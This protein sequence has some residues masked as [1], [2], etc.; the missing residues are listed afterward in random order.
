MNDIP[1]IP[2]VEV[3]HSSFSRISADV[4]DC[5]CEYCKQNSIFDLFRIKNRIQRILWIFIIFLLVIACYLMN[6]KLFQERHIFIVNEEEKLSTYDIP[7]PAVTVC[8]D[9]KADHRKFKFLYTFNRIYNV[10]QEEIIK[11]LLLERVLFPDVTSR[12][13]INPAIGGDTLHRPPID[14]ALS[15]IHE[16]G[17]KEEDLIVQCSIDNQKKCKWTK[18]LTPDGLCYSFNLISSKEM[19]QPNIEHK[20]YEDMGISSKG[21]SSNE[22]YANRHTKDTYPMR[23]ERHQLKFR[24][25]LDTN[26][27]ENISPKIYL[28]LG[29]FKGFYIYVHHPMDYPYD[30]QNRVFIPTNSKYD[31]KIIPDLML[32]DKSLKKYAMKTRKCSFGD[33]DETNIK[34]FNHFSINNCLLECAAKESL[35]FCECV[36]FFMP[37]ENKTICGQSERH[38]QHCYR[39]S[40]NN[41]I[42]LDLLK[43]QNFNFSGS[44]CNCIPPCSYLSYTVYESMIGDLKISN[45][46][47]QFSDVTIRFASTKFIPKRRQE[48]SSD[49]DM[50]AAIGG[51]LGLFIGA[52]VISIIEFFYYFS[53]KLSMRIVFGNK[54][55]LD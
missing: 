15:R 42:T 23:A 9:V 3:H 49:L 11:Y 16:L 2:V 46:S 54:V 48:S 35:K 7:F 14:G 43:M 22:G 4:K 13:L 21:W 37:N 18:I 34:F 41:M 6:V 5:L 45:G 47:F 39:H 20:Q 17:I 29:V 53:F 25:K 10:S 24:L 28:N 33:S 30:I 1:E 8:T 38:T 55:S 19:F 31:L 12:R 51:A 26:D 27:F 36:Q 44:V 52:S 40:I 50:L 32:A